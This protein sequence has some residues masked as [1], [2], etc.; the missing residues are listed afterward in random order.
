[1]SNFLKNLKARITFISSLFVLLAVFAAC[2]LPMGLGEPID[3]IPPVLTLDPVPTP[4]YVRTGAVLTGTVT[5]NVGVDR[6][7]LRDAL[8]KDLIISDDMPA[9]RAVITGERWEMMLSFDESRNGEKMTVEV[10]AYDRAGNSGDTSIKSLT[11]IIDIGPPITEDVWMKRSDTRDAFFESYNELKT[12]RNEPRLMERVANVNRFQNGFFNILATISEGETRI[13]DT[14]RLNIYDADKDIDQLL[15]Q[16]EITED[17]SLYSPKWLISEAE[18]LAEGEKLWSGYSA[19]YEAGASYIYRVA[20]EVHDRSLNEGITL[21]EEGYFLMS[22]AADEPKGI[23]DPVVGSTVT[24]GGTIPVEFFDDDQLLWAYTGLLTYDQWHGTEPI[25]SGVF[26]PK[27]DEGKTAKDKLAFL[28]TRLRAD[29]PVYNWRYDRYPGNTSEPVEELIKGRTLNERTIYLLAGNNETDYGQF[30]LFSIVADK[31]LAPHTNDGPRDTNRTRSVGRHWPID[32]IDENAPLIV[33][34]VDNGCPEENTF[35]ILASG[36]FFTIKGYTLR[37][38][39]NKQNGVIKLRVAWIPSGK[40]GGADSYI[41]Q[42]QT[43]LRADNYPA[44]ISANPNLDGVQY[45]DFGFA[46]LAPDGLTYIYNSEDD[47]KIGDNWFR[48]QPFERTFSVLG[49]STSHFTR[50]PPTPPAGAAWKDF[51]YN[52]ASGGCLLDDN[53]NPVCRENE[54]KLFVIFAECNMGHQVYR[55]MR[56]LGNRT[57]PNLFVYDISGNILDQ[58]INDIAAPKIPN[59]QLPN[60]GLGIPNSTYDTDLRAFNIRD[61]VYTLFKNVSINAAGSFVIEERQRAIP[62]QMYTWGT[63]LKYWARALPNGDLRVKEI[64]MI[65]ITTDISKQVGSE[66]RAD[67]NSLVF[68]E[69]YPDEAQRVFL[70]EAVDS[71]GNIARMQRTIAVTNAARLEKI[72]TE[73]LNGTYGIGEIIELQADFSGQIRV[74]LGTQG[75]RPL[76]NVRYPVKNPTTGIVSHQIEQ[77]PA[78][79]ENPGDDIT[80]PTLFLKFRFTVPVNAITDTPPVPLRTMYDGGG[81]GGDSA[82][83]KHTDRPLSLLQGTRIIDVNRDQHAFIPGYTVGNASMPNWITDSGSLQGGVTNAPGKSIFLDGIRPTISAVS[84]SGKDPASASD[85]YFRDG[86]TIELAITSEKQIINSDEPRLQFI[87]RDLADNNDLVTIATAF[88]YSRQG[89]ANQLIF[90]LPVSSVTRDG[91]INNI[92]IFT[93]TGSTGKITDR[94]GNELIHTANLKTFTPALTSMNLNIKRTLPAMPVVTLT[95]SSPSLNVPL[96]SAAQTYNYGVTMTISPSAAIGGFAPWENTV[97]YSLDGGLTWTEQTTTS[98]VTVNVTNGTHNIRARYKDLAGNEGYQRH[99]CTATTNPNSETCANTRNYSC[100]GTIQINADFPRLNAVTAVQSTGWFT[101][102]TGQ[103]TLTFNLAFDEQVRV[104]QQIV[105]RKDSATTNTFT[106]R[107]AADTANANHDLGAN[108][109]VIQ[110]VRYTQA[111]GT[112]GNYFLRIISANTFR[113]YTTLAAANAGTANGDSLGA[114]G[115]GTIYLN[116]EAVSITLKNRNTANNSDAVTA[117]AVIQLQAAPGQTTLRS[118]IRFDWQ[119]ITGKEMPDGL[120]VFDVTLTGLRD[121]FGNAGGSGTATYSGAAQTGTA[122]QIS[123]TGTTP[124]HVCAN[125]AAGYRVDAINPTIQTRTPANTTVSGNNTSITL[126]FSEPVMRGSGTITIRPRGNFA[127]PPVFEDEGYWLGTDANGTRYYAPTAGTTYVKSLFEVYNDSS[128]TAAERNYLTEGTTAASQIIDTN[129]A[130][131]PSSVLDSTNPSMS[132]LRLNTRTGQAVGPYI[133]TTHGLTTG[134]GYTGNYNNTTPGANGP[135]PAAAA[136]SEFMVPDT[137]TKWVLDYRYLIHDTTANS[138]VSRIRA[139]LTKTKF[140]WQE[141]DVLATGLSA[142]NRTVTITFNEPLLKGLQWDVYMPA[143]AFTDMAG[144]S[145]TGIGTFNTDG[146]TSGTTDYW[147]WSSGVQE[148]VIR[149]N[150]R[151]FDARTA[152][153][154]RRNANATVVADGGYSSPGNTTGWSASTVVSDTNGWGIGDFN[155]I[156]YRVESE[157]PGAAIQVAALQ[158]STNAATAAGRNSRG[159]AIA[160]FTD[161]DSVLVAN[162]DATE[163]TATNW[164]AAA[165]NTAGQWVLSNIIRR[166]RNNQAVQYTVTTK[167]GTSELRQFA[168][169]AVFRGFRSYNRDAT[170]AEIDAVTKTSVTLTNSS[171]QS[172]L[173]FGAMEANKSYI[174][175]TATLTGQ[176]TATGYE[177][178]FRTVIAFFYDS[179]QNA[180]NYIA[181]EGSNIKNGM[182]SIA[183]F[184]VRD[185]EETGD[186]RFIKIFHNV[187]SRRTYYWVSTEI[188]CEWYFLSWGGG[189]RSGGNGTHQNVGEVN[190]YQ[191]V[192]YGDLTYGYNITR[193]N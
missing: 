86:D 156:H 3:F 47:E 18:I 44:S 184:P 115:G 52:C 98:S 82:A 176:P 105:A 29:E 63:M 22:F 11:I 119:N 84:I 40:D 58:R 158:G 131:A 80:K 20:T 10:V 104:N 7:V 190:N 130:T 128:L 78:Y 28:E 185:A 99:R 42:V 62:F 53:G 87:V 138:A 121:S 157:S 151:T 15:L 50:N 31:K 6:V 162:T 126:E 51:H 148:P 21:E 136:A 14:L 152:S 27:T 140:R 8:T 38:N 13:N 76:L 100:A 39:G 108:G 49:N 102:N 60:Y 45:W 90:S 109:N 35:P 96:Q 69:Y 155:L 160:S 25:A 54:N 83:D 135:N 122:S 56:L 175:A 23:L 118:S 91:R 174:T 166:S 149:V 55:Q 169:N 188:V 46:H 171:Y 93:G 85:Y 173:T 97:Q 33:L 112:A 183:G 34:D 2:D 95:S 191:T 165:T 113:L 67:D 187:T 88:S 101:A 77:L 81:L 92:T 168:T 65:D 182:P 189:N 73:T 178:I 89:S 24:R 146:T 32:V 179:N 125:L 107:N 167:A 114:A 124:T 147:F 94:V 12:L 142:D 180:S 17:S 16:V 61:D 193:Y 43:A 134:V 110:N 9:G 116:N 144:N 37:E 129:T 120:Y 161:G 137:A 111:N 181:I 133:K 26:L 123:M 139:V 48:M 141:I 70:F 172:A 153:W 127:I 71:L 163:V 186:N 1:M 36:E 75:Q 30:F 72:T 19:A 66:Y 41:P 106:S 64:R 79:I 59:V 159:A 170:K 177:G 164:N 74:E 150:R 192:G 103:N 117:P 143:G 68:I 132:R 145:A 4:L 154:H 57:P 5:D